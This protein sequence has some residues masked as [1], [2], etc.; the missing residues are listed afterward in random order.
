MVLEIYLVRGNF[1]YHLGNF[2]LYCC[3][4]LLKWYSHRYIWILS[5]HLEKPYVVLLTHV[6]F[7][8]MRCLHLRAHQLTKY[9][10]VNHW[11]KF[12]WFWHNRNLP[13]PIEKTMAAIVRKMFLFSKGHGPHFW[14]SVKEQLF[15]FNYDE[16]RNWCHF[17]PFQISRTVLPWYFSNVHIQNPDYSMIIKCQHV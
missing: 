8:Y 12:Y 2:E 16:L 10:L 5:Q 4:L 15:L 9:R 6:L 17:S 13:L 14:A 1:Q 7:C 3:I 11:A